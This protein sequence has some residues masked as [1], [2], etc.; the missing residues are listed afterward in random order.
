MNVGEIC[1]RKVII[2]HPDDSIHQTAKLMRDHHVG[3][4]IVT[5]RRE[6]ELIPIGI[7]TDRDIVIEL[8]AEEVDLDSVSCADVMCNDLIT[9]R[10]NDEIL[11]TIE[12]M[13]EKGIRRLPVVNQND[14]LE[15]ILT[16]D[17][18]IE[19]LAELQTNLA[20]LI[21]REMNRERAVH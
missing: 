15:G 4:L 5:E 16:L 7:L 17:D 14:G 20:K 19:L 3:D 18:I 13:R 9:A 2:C 6:D 1:N 12:L 11:V 8:L 10:E 21:G